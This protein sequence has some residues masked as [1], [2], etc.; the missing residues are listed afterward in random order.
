LK[1]FFF[2]KNTEVA[3]ENGRTTKKRWI[4]KKKKKKRKD[5]A[6]SQPHLFILSLTT[7]FVW[8]DYSHYEYKKRS[9][10]PQDRKQKVK[11]SLKKKKA[12]LGGVQYLTLTGCE[13]AEW[14][15]VEERG[16]RLE[17]AVGQAGELEAVV[18]L[19]LGSYFL[20]AGGSFR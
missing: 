18:L 7:R 19:L 2:K 16:R 5:V 9:G 4:Q 10:S 12:E 6:V 8:N 1:F 15:G 17:L 3:L 13:I 20:A 11:R 14:S